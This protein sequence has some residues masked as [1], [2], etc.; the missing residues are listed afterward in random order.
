MNVRSIVAAALVP[1]LVLGAAACGSGTNGG[2]F[3]SKTITVVVPFDAG[4]GSDAIARQVASDL[5]SELDAT[6]VVENKPGAA[7]VL[8]TNAVSQAAADGYTLLST[9]SFAFTA[10]PALRETKY[11]PDDFDAIAEE[12]S[13]GL[14]HLVKADAPWKSAEEMLAERGELTYGNPGAGGMIQVAQ[15]ALF[16]EGEVD[17]QGVPFDG[18]APAI[19]A[20]LGG[21]IDT[22][23]AEIGVA[24]PYI[25]SGDLK[26]L[27]VTTPERVESLADVPTVTEAGYPDATVTAS[28]VLLAPAGLPE[29][30]LAA[31]EEAVANAVAGDK[32]TSFL[33]EG[34]YEPG[35]VTGSDLDKQMKTTSTSVTGLIETLGIMVDE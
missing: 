24:L 13:Y 34:Q 7:G 20:L 18:S 16:A 8:G 28:E 22:T 33:E 9:N 19:T 23:A 11:G 35:D 15:A 3:P 6:V 32:V 31:L 25:K 5:E 14:V 27:A 30:V 17:A 21:Q 26:A 2:S 12:A 4:G 10:Q 29:E 1:T